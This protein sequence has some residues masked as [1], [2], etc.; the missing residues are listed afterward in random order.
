MCGYLGAKEMVLLCLGRVFDALECGDRVEVELARGD[1]DR[2]F[3][4]CVSLSG[5]GGV[6]GAS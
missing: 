4:E 6:S 2:W 3:A 5:V 1:M